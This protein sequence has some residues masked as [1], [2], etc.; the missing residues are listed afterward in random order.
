MSEP[1][2]SSEKL[3]GKPDVVTWSCQKHLLCT[4]PLPGAFNILVCLALTPSRAGPGAS[5]GLR[6]GVLG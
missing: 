6:A 4:Q 5:L 2:K 1:L 3:Q